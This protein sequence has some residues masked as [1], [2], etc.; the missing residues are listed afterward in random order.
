MPNFVAWM[1]RLFIPLFSYFLIK[2]R[3]ELVSSFVHFNKSYKKLNLVL[4]KSQNYF[5][6]SKYSNFVDSVKISKNFRSGAF[7][8][9]LNLQNNTY[10]NAKKYF[11][12]IHGNISLSYEILEL[13]DLPHFKRLKELRQIPT[14]SYA[15]NKGFHTRYEHSIGT[16]YVGNKMIMYLRNKHPELCITDREVLMITIASLC[17]DIG[18]GPFS[19]LFDGQIVP[20][21]TNNKWSHEDAS[22]MLVDDIF[23]NY[24][25][26]MFSIEEID[27][28]KAMINPYK[29]PKI[30]KSGVREFLYQ[31]VANADNGIDVDKMDYLQRDYYYL[32]DRYINID[33]DKIIENSKIINGQICYGKSIKPLIQNMFM[34][35]NYMHYKFYTHASTK[36]IENIIVDHILSLDK[37]YNFVACL[38]DVK[39]YLLLT[40]NILLNEKIFITNKNVPSLVYE[41]SFTDKIDVDEMKDY[42]KNTFVDSTFASLTSINFGFKDKNPVN[43]AIFYDDSQNVD[44]Q[45]DEYKYHYLNQNNIT[46]DTIPPLTII[47]VFSK[48]KNVKDGNNFVS[49]IAEKMDKQIDMFIQNSKFT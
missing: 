37:K 21:L 26:N 3:G 24:I 2:T 30:A 4:C 31:I 15:F 19:H 34:L 25:T 36:A 23:T 8:I 14:T 48:E 39:K 17:H 46:F 22:T 29:Y 16:A 41:R 27:M 12:D 38:S 33:F 10:R 35:R 20:L 5:V 13:L 43:L 42:L 32:H 7:D 9:M 1:F 47:R 40:D 6:C 28:I 45:N 18:H 44:R 49:F 11:D